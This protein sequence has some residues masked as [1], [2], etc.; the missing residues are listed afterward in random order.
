MSGIFAFIKRSRAITMVLVIVMIIT[1]FAGC[2]KET[3]ENEEKDDTQ[4]SV[5]V[6]ENEKDAQDDENSEDS[7]EEQEPE[8]YTGPY[9]PLTGEPVE[10]DISGNRPYA[11]MLNNLKKAVPQHGVSKADIIYECV[12]EGGI[13]R[14]MA[15]YQDLSDVDVIGSA[16]SAR[17][18]YLDL[19]QAIDAIYIHAGGSGDAYELMS[20][21]K[22]THIDG[23]NGNDYIFYRDKDRK[24][25]MGY[26]H[27]LMIDVSLIPEFIDKYDIRSEHKD[28][29]E[30]NMQFKDD[31]TPENG[32]KAES[33]T[34]HMSSSK[35]TNFEYNASDKL[36]YVNQYKGAMKDGNNDEQ[37]AVTNVLV[38][39]A[40]YTNIPG[41]TEGRLKCELTGSGTGYFICGGQKIDINWS[42][43]DYSSQFVYTLAD[44]TELEFGRGTSF[45]CIAPTGATVEIG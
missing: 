30:Y 43:S 17:P 44:G 26:E 39:F 21:R 36:Y 11:I 9:N 13:T 18:Y 22:M 7:E 35:T 34:V 33:I 40:K 4:A 10:E 42:K 31:G 19:A 8:I 1:L 29:F 2:S 3:E 12:V 41:D 5:S 28:G 32:T 16:R 45:I 38:L 27:S 6:D 24:A 23:V 14:F 25:T 37:V 15:V 20:S